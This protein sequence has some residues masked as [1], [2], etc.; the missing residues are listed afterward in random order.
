VI[1][2]AAKPVVADDID[3]SW[4]D[5]IAALADLGLYC[6]LSGLRTE[7]PSGQAASALRPFIN[8][9]V[10]RFETRLMW[11]SDWPV[12]RLAGDDFA[13]WLA[14][15]RDLSAGADEAQL[16]AGCATD[17]YDTIT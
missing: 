5:G 15:A 12:L 11:S 16:F 1:D 3:P 10:A 7:Q 14:A 8:H 4:R 13:D 6:K 17:F 9:L 2:H